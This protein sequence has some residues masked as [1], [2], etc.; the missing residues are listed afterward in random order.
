[1]GD[2]DLTDA[3]WGL[4]AEL[5]ALCEQWEAEEAARKDTAEAA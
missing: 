4:M 1:M 3:E 2:T 5:W